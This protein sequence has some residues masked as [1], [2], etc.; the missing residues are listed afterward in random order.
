MNKLRAV[1]FGWLWCLL[2]LL[3]GTQGFAQ[4]PPPP[5]PPALDY[6]PER[7][8]EFSYPES[9]FKIRLP[10]EPRHTQN[11]VVRN[12][13]KVAVTNVLYGS[14]SFISY[15]VNVSAFPLNLEETGSRDM[16]VGIR[17]AALK[18]SGSQ[19]VSEKEFTLDGHSGQFL[20]VEVEQRVVL[21]TKT[22]L[23]GGRLYQAVVTTQIHGPERF[24]AENGYEKIAMSFL[25]S[26]SLL[27][28]AEL[29]ADEPKAAVKEDSLPRLERELARLAKVTDGTVGVVAI[30]LESGRRVTLNN[31]E[32]YP[33]ASTF[34][35]PVAVQLLTLVDEGKL[36]LDQ[37][38]ELKTS[39]LSPGSG[40]LSDLFNKPGVALSLRNLL[41]LMLL[42]SDNSATDV[43]LRL[44]GGGEAVTAR[45][46]ALGIEGINVNRSTR[47][48]IADWLGIQNLPPRAEHT[49]E[50]YGKL[51]RAVTPEQGKAANEKFNADARDTATPDGMARLLERIWKKDCLKPASAELLY[52]IMKRC[53]TGDARL[54]GLLPRGTEVAH[55]TGSIG[56]SANDV[57]IITLP[58]NAGHV[59]LAVFVKAATKDMA[60]RE[61]AIAEIARAVHDYFLYN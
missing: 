19:L 6:A 46:R 48:L 13:V 22:V 21:R 15:S 3:I 4:D 41:E 31:G 59:A 44:A 28:V 32:R 47:E 38:V 45:M 37:M 10:G 42:I 8:K 16:F 61:R 1:S 14:A 56:G 35:V 18:R 2:A 50:G 30:H 23:V 11:E 36:T 33:M 51:A 26:F 5:P 55:K 7:W 60:E 12:G 57:G 24:R 39:D 58:D 40:T 9:G 25:D 54:K 20:H 53:R 52:D 34:K 29:K 43:C 27:K 17:E 49:L